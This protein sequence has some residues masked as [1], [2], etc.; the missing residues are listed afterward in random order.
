MKGP[1]ARRL[2]LLCFV[3]ALVASCAPAP[4]PS[5]LPPD[6]GNWEKT[7]DLVLNY[8]IPG[9]EDRLRVPRMNQVG[10]DYLARRGRGAGTWDYPAG[11]VIAKAVY[12]SKAP[13][14]GEGPVQVT[15]MIKAPS[16]ARA[17]GGW[18]W[19]ARDLASGKEMVFTGEFCFTC[20]ENANE[21]HPYAD[22]N[23]RGEYRDYVFILPGAGPE[24]AG[25][26]AGG[27]DS[28]AGEAEEYGS[29]P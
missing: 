9:H 3:G 28:A 16:D 5:L 1:G 7:T 6:W 22:K 8:P 29:K 24:P 20:H 2:P 18:L 26:E 12:A 13:A 15:A 25:K 10:F 4:A 23:P 11:T 17:R 27:A 21:S 14:K 19:V